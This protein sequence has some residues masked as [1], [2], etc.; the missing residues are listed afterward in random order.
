MQLLGGR[1][2]HPVLDP[3]NQFWRTRNAVARGVAPAP[4]L[5]TSPLHCGRPEMQLLGGWHLHPGY[6]PLH[7]I[8]EDLRCSCSGGGTCTQFS[9]PLINFGGLE[10]QLLG[11]WHLH[12]GCRPL[13][14]HCGRPEMQLLGGRHLHPVLDPSNQFW[15]TRNAVA[16]GVAPA[17]WFKRELVDGDGVSQSPC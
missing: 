16:R 9:I 14:L 17:P 8:V 4:W 12:P 2:L 7:S 13:L 6:R 5:P 1:H 3:S 11:G 15:R 10:M